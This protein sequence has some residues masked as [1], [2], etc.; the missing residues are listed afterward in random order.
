[1]NQDEKAA[2]DAAKDAEAAL[3]HAIECYE[4]AGFGSLVSQPL[5]DARAE[6]RYSLREVQS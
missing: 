3:T 1:M 5:H 2:I 4:L 6:V